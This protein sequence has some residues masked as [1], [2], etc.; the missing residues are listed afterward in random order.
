MVMFPSFFYSHSS[1]PLFISS[2]PISSATS[3]VASTIKRRIAAAAGAVVCLAIKVARE[4]VIEHRHCASELSGTVVIVSGSA[5]RCSLTSIVFQKR[6][7]G[8][9]KG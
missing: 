1:A 5:S 4:F 9:A 3:G 8:A 6:A 2:A 7:S